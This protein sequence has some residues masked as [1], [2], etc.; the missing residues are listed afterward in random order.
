[1]NDLFISIEYNNREF[2]GIE[3]FK[4]SLAENYHHQIRPKWI[5]ACSEGAEFW[6][7]VFV[8]TGIADFIKGAIA[9]GLVWDLI[10]FGGKEY[11]FSPLYKSLEKLNKDNSKNWGGLK[12]LKYKLQ[13]DDCELHV[14]GVNKNFTSIF[15]TVFNEIAK[16]KPEFEKEI[17]Q[18][19]IKIELPIEFMEH[20]EN[21]NERF[22]LD[23]YNEDYSI[24]AFKNIWRVTF[25]TEFPIMI[26][27]FSEKKLFEPKE[28][29]DKLKTPASNV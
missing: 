4:S 21:V 26:Y 16:R 2:D 6:M 12:V 22:S 1:M 9:G 23:I 19:V 27:S 25:S 15:S 11:V 24:K 28:M 7:T 13:F 8:N 18:E 29:S 20:F 17:G 10:K 3:E 5:P 14:G